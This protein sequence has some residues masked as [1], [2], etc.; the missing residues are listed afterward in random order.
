MAAARNLGVKLSTGD[1]IAFLDSDDVWLP[2]HLAGI[3]P[4]ITTAGTVWGFTAVKMPERYYTTGNKQWPDLLVDDCYFDD[5]FSAWGGE[6]PLHINGMVIRRN[7]LSNLGGFNSQM[8]L[9]EDLDLWFRIGLRYP[10]MAFQLKPCVL[11]NRNRPGSLTS[12][13][14]ADPRVYLQLLGMISDAY[15]SA[16]VN[17]KKA[18]RS[19][20]RRLARFTWVAWYLDGDPAFLRML[21]SSAI[22]LPLAQRVQINASANCPSAVR[23]AIGIL[24]KTRSAIR[25]IV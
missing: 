12:M 8:P 15:S 14:G 5:F 13:L 23:V 21:S 16:S 6:A 19:S 4:R 22:D 9:G 20:N 25:R 2:C 1:F 18:F 24:K 3:M 11:Y 10:K 17:R 7:A